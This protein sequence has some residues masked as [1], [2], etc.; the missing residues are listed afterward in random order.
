MLDRRDHR[1]RR[2][3]AEAEL[4][5]NGAAYRRSAAGARDHAGDVDSGFLEESFFDRHAVRRPGWIRLVLGD[6][7]VLCG[8][9][10]SCECEK[11]SKDGAGRDLEHGFLLS[12]FLDF[13]AA[14]TKAYSDE[15]SGGVGKGAQFR[16]GVNTSNRSRSVANAR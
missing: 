12:T 15:L 13:Y 16:H 3:V 11:R 14:R 2:H 6:D 7:N 10:R 4:A 1:R 8:R 5:R 9:G